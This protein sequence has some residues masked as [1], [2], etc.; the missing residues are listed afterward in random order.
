MLQLRP[1]D[2]RRCAKARN[3]TL[4]SVEAATTLCHAYR[5]LHSACSVPTSE[6]RGNETKF[7][8]RFAR[9]SFLR[10][11]TQRP[12]SYMKK[13]KAGKGCSEELREA[14]LCCCTS[15]SRE[16]WAA[17]VVRAYQCTSSRRV[18]GVIARQWF[19]PSLWLIK[20]CGVK[21]RAGR[22]GL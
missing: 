9:R 17:S 11:H 5:C 1:K 20:N 14:S 19:V 6:C 13:G 2:F 15:R 10:C 21:A 7:K 18:A 3:V 8:G 4:C 16:D 22:C 12:A